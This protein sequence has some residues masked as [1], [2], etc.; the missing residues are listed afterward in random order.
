MHLNDK[1]EIE[2]NVKKSGSSFYWGMKLLPEEKRRAMFSIYAFC[3]EVDDIAD[4]LKS[5]KTS[6]EKKLKLWKK[7]IEKIFKRSSL[8]TSLK[9]ELNN[10][11]MNFKLEKKDFF[12]IIDGMLMDVKSDIQFPSLKKFKLY[13][14]RVAVA[15]GYLSIKIFGV[16]TKIGNNYAYELGMAFQITNIVRDFHEDLENKRCYIPSEKFDKYR[17]KKNI[18]ELRYNSNDIQV[19]LQEMLTIANKHFKKADLL[20]KDLDKKKMI[21]SIIMRLFYKKIHSKM[22]KKKINLQKKVKL[23]F[24]DKIFIFFQFSL[25]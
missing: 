9:R 14:E 15:V 19:V 16:E 18:N 21:G 4:D 2:K 3:R 1:L 11:I 5:S 23:N 22:F 8:N 12:S 24:F 25:R 10:S 17:L 6:K 7:D 20:L 13:C